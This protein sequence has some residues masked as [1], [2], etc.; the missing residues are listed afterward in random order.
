LLV[1]DGAIN[2]DA[3]TA[4]ESAGAN[5][6]HLPPFSPDFHPIEL[7]FYKFSALLRCAKECTVEAL[8]QTCGKLHDH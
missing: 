4:I 2:D 1:R 3:R 6:R 7:A 5:V 8:W